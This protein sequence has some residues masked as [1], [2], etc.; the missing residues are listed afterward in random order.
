MAVLSARFGSCSKAV[1]RAHRMD[2]RQLRDYTD[3]DAVG[4][5]AGGEVDI[6]YD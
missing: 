6:S 3:L 2:R 1:F 4:P 5:P